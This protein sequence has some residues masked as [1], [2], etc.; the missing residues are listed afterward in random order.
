MIGNVVRFNDL[1]GRSHEYWRKLPLPS[2]PTDNPNSVSVILSKVKKLDRSLWLPASLTG[3]TREVV[4]I[5]AFG[6]VAAERHD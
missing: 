6:S 4:F 3:G 1:I 2:R 5:V